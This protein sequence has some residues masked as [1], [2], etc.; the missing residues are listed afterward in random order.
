M[1][2]EWLP[3]HS[4]PTTGQ[5]YLKGPRGGKVRA[6]WCFGIFGIPGWH[7]WSG[8]ELIRTGSTHWKPIPRKRK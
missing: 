7:V 6:T 5:V 1:S 4:A 2:T 8:D 3:I